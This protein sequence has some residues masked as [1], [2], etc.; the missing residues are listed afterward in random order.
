MPNDLWVKAMER[1]DPRKT[2]NSENNDMTITCLMACA[3]A[4]TMRKKHA[5]L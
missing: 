4:M 1:I 2:G 5:L 3:R